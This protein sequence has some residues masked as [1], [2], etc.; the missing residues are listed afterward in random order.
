MQLTGIRIPD[1]AIARSNNASA[2]LDH[3][4]KKP[5]PS[6]V[7]DALA[8]QENL[9]ALPNVSVFA[10]RVTT[11]DK[12]RSVGRWKVIEAELVARGLP[13]TGH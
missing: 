10:K 4:V 1:H 8:E 7:V 2:L 13:V 11:I 12:E 6:R 9:L 5:R 3:L